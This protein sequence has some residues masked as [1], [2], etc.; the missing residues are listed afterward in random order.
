MHI[1]KLKCGVV[2]MGH[3]GNR[4][5]AMIKAH[6]DCELQAVCDI[7]YKQD[8]TIQNVRQYSDF[9]NFIKHEELDLLSVC[10]PNH[11]H[12]PFSMQA[13]NHDV[14][15]LCEKP[16]GLKS[17]S[18]RILI[19]TAKE[20]NKHIFCV[21]QNR[22]SP[23]VKW[24]QSLIREERMGKIFHVQIN[25]FWNRDERYYLVPDERGMLQPH[26]WHGSLEKDGGPL[27][28]QFSHFVDILI[29]LF[30]RIQVKDV[31]FFDF[32]HSQITEFE[33]SGSIQFS[34]ETN[35]QGHFLYSTAIWGQNAESS[36]N[37]IGSKGTVKVG[38]QYMN[39][40][41]YCHIEDYQAPDL[42]VTNNANQY[43]GYSGSANNHYLIFN[44]VADVILRGESPDFPIED[45]VHG[46]EVIENIYRKRQKK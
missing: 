11:L 1:K 17:E 45:A 37:I 28:T 43:G 4:H 6:P 9:A 3:I 21:L 19:R 10:V 35:V 15:V 23:T 42:P 18:S 31:S 26:P 39:R 30:G 27:F 7:K 12:I 33:D 29:A 40:I 22:Y 2:G 14:H 25:C 16:L 44:N 38:G 36:I 5:A 32:N 20:K 13:I 41:D 34:T 24:L 46:V 8:S